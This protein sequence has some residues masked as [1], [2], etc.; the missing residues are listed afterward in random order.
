[1]GSRGAFLSNSAHS[2]LL[3]SYKVDPID[4]TGAGDIFNGALAKSLSEDSD[5]IEAIKFANAAAAI[6]VT[7]FGAQASAPKES[8]IRVL[9]G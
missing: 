4:T 2:L 9:L 5:I 8:E 7:K 6:S 3:P 1:M